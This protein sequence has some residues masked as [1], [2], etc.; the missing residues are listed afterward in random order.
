MK[1]TILLSLLVIAGC[2]PNSQAS[3]EEQLWECWVENAAKQG[4][5]LN[6][7]F[8]KFEKYLVLGG[9]LGGTSG[10]DYYDLFQKWHQN[11][12]INP[13]LTDNALDSLG[14]LPKHKISHESD[15]YQQFLPK[16]LKHSVNDK[17]AQMNKAVEEI[18]NSGD[19]GPSNIIE[20]LL[21]NFSPSDLDKPF[22]KVYSLLYVQSLI[23][24]DTRFD[25]IHHYN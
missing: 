20:P 14:K 19:V 10:Q 5:D 1:W 6:A 21:N 17:I 22:Y 3:Y 9:L 13:S 15:C 18:M 16:L 12:D 24:V 25:G 7:D 11:G 2:K 4:L 23:A 8:K